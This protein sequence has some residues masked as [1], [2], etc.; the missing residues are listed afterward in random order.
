M[1]RE[2][3]DEARWLRSFGRNVR[4]ERERAKLSQEQLAATAG[5]HRTYLGSLERGE[6]NVALINI[7]KLARALDV[8]P[9]V[10]L[11]LDGE[12]GMQP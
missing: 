11:R 4:R 3:A 2:E 8:E 7:H 10:L 6:R 12:G 9:G 1:L 5:V